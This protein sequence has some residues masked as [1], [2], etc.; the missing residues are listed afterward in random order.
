MK[1]FDEATVA[2]WAPNKNAVDNGRE[3]AEKGAFVALNRDEEGTI[4]FGA[5]FG[6]GKSAYQ[7]SV[8]FVDADNPV[9]RC[10]CPSRQ[11]PCKHVLGLLFA[12]TRKGQKGFAVAEIPAAILEKRSNAAQRKQRKPREKEGP[13]TVDLDAL[14]K[15]LRVQIDGLDRAMAFVSDILKKGLGGLNAAMAPGL[16]E[17]ADLLIGQYLGGASILFRELAAA[18][19]L[20]D[21]E[22]GYTRALDILVRINALCARGARYLES[23]LSDPAAAPGEDRWIDEMLGRAWQLTELRE[24]GMTR[25]DVELLQLS[26]SCFE[27]EA[28]Q[29]FVDEAI[30]MDLATGSVER[31]VTYRPFRAK[32]HLK[33]ED[34][35]DE[36]VLVP[37]LHVY[38]DRDRNPRI[39]WD[40]ATFRKRN[41][42]DISRA[43]AH[44]RPSLSAVVKETRDQVKNPL[45]DRYPLALVGPCDVVEPK[46]AVTD[47]SPLLRD[48]EGTLL[49]LADA[50]GGPEGSTAS[51]LR[52]LDPARLSGCAVLLRMHYDPETGAVLAQPLSVLGSGPV[53]PFWRF[54]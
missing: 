37:K 23:R 27:D 3:L 35:A 21:R 16:K 17:Q 52:Y 10:S 2:S 42:A 5:C 34:S 24:L 28:R 38:P 19:V 44:A 13:R 30:W 40:H 32:K 45:A 53:A 41:N 1:Q 18:T 22:A 48:L 50:E 43:F 20:E 11:T 9:F 49:S 12:W 39:R 51:L 26:F 31:S 33:E 36:V 6:S 25:K 54:V 4:L 47:A 15:K 46:H 7:C 8:N 14:A 29:E